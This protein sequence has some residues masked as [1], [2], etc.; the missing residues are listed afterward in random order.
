MPLATVHELEV[1]AQ[2]AQAAGANDKTV[3][4]SEEP[5][6]ELPQKGGKAG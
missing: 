1:T 6:V 5:T 3:E 4:I 2:M